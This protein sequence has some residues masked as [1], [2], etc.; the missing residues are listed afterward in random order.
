MGLFSSKQQDPIEWAGLPSEPLENSTPDIAP[1][2]AH[3][4]DL[5]IA[6]VDL[7]VAGVSAGYVLIPVAVTVPEHSVVSENADPNP[8]RDDDPDANPTADTTPDSEDS[9]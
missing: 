2:S 5:G 8:D 1:A 3:A 4:T 6:G 7:G 9:H